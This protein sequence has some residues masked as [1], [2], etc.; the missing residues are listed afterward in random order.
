MN[1]ELATVKKEKP[2]ILQLVIT[3][4]FIAFLTFIAETNNV[5][6]V[7]SVALIV[8]AVGYNGNALRDTLAAIRDKEKYVVV[9][10][11]SLKNKEA[12]AFIKEIKMLKDKYN[13]IK[14]VIFTIVLTVAL[15]Y[16]SF[17]IPVG[18]TRTSAIIVSFIAAYAIY[19]YMD[20]YTGKVVSARE[21]E[22]IA[23]RDPELIY[24][25]LD[26]SRLHI[27]TDIDKSAILYVQALTSYYMEDYDNTFLK[28]E[29]IGEL[30]KDKRIEILATAL[31]G[32]ACIRTGNVEGYNDAYDMIY[33][34]QDEC[35][36][37]KQLR[38]MC[39]VVINRMNVLVGLM[40]ETP[41]KVLDFAVEAVNEAKN[42]ELI[43]MEFTFVLAELQ[44]MMGL[45]E[46]AQSNY[47]TVAESAGKMKIRDIAAERLAG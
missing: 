13:L 33:S 21:R 20:F 37:N 2:P 38:D 12:E 22:I 25:Y 9:N 11:K 17:K 4:V 28:I 8:F 23:M 47:K 36:K 24:E 27:Y 1:E 6:Y 3:L 19:M 29:K 7:I 16:I 26:Q 42:H 40:D 34:L 5:I 39:D 14:S 30:N 10:K 45:T 43:K 44:D 41:D 18:P 15:T 31:L 32:Q 35:V 46:L